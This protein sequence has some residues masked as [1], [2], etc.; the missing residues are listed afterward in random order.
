LSICVTSAVA[1]DTDGICFTSD[2]VVI[3]V[4]IVTILSV[5]CTELRSSEF[6]VVV[7]RDCGSVSLSNWCLAICWKETTDKIHLFLAKIKKL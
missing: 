7:N 5:V 6:K 3:S 1:I 4:T 2:S